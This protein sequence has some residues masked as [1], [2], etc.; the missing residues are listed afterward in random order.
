M[1]VLV[2]QALKTLGKANVTSRTI[3][4]LNSRLSEEDKSAMLKE[5]A[6]STDWVY[7]AIRQI[8]GEVQQG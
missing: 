5:A 3:K 2:I 8:A 1:T 7:N 6:E 4:T